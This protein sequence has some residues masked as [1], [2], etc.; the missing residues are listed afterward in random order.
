MLGVWGIVDGLG[1]LFDRD[2]PLVM[3]ELQSFFGGEFAA[4]IDR[5]ILE[6]APVTGRME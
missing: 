1:I 4:A 6:R 5:V 3:K 2:P